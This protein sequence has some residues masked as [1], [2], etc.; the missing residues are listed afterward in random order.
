MKKLIAPAIIFSLTLITLNEIKIKQAVR[1]ENIIKI[2]KEEEF[3]QE[4]ELREIERFQPI[5]ST[6]PKR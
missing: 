5:R 6:T 2:Q 3:K 4:K 1:Q